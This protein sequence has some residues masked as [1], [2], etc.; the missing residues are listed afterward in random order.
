MI[1]S[2]FFENVF[3]CFLFLTFRHDKNKRRAVEVSEKLYDN[4]DLQ[5]FLQN[6]QDVSSPSVYCAII[7]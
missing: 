6:T 4:R 1:R 5:R 7:V 3:V 2:C